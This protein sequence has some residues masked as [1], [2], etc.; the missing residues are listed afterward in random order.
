MSIN[1]DRRPFYMASISYKPD[2]D[3]YEESQQ[4]ALCEHLLDQGYT[5][6]VEPCDKMPLSV[7]QNLELQYAGL[8]R[9]QTRDQAGE[10]VEIPT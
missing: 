7:R 3:I 6:I 5:V 4:L 9:F 2:T 8:I 1:P 10:A